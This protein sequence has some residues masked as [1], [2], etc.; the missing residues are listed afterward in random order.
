M[1]VPL[2]VYRTTYRDNLP[3]QGLKIWQNGEIHTVES[4]I[5]PYFLSSKRLRLKPNNF[6]EELITVKPLNDFTPQEFYKYSF[7]FVENVNDV[8]GYVRTDNPN[9]TPELLQSMRE[10]HMVFTERVAIDKP[11][12][13]R[14]YPDNL[15]S[16]YCFDI[17]TLNQ[18]FVDQNQIIAIS[19]SNTKEPAWCHIGRE[20]NILE[21]FRNDFR[22]LDPD[23]VVGFNHKEF[24][25][26]YVL[27]RMK[28]HNIETDF[29]NRNGDD[30]DVGR[31]HTLHGRCMYDVYENVNDDQTIRTKNKRLKTVARDHF[32]FPAIEEDLS[33]GTDYLLKDPTRLMQYCNSDV[34]TTLKI[35]DGY[36]A[37]SVAIANTIGYP[38]DNLNN[39][40][41]AKDGLD[42][43]GRA[44][45]GLW[46]L[47]GRLVIGKGMVNENYIENRSNRDKHPWAK[48]FQGA[49]SGIKRTGRF[50]NVIHVDV[51][52]M[53]PSIQRSFNISPDTT[54]FVDFEPFD[55]TQHILREK[56]DEYILFCIPDE[57][58]KQNCII[59]V[60]LTRT[61][62]MPEFLTL[63]KDE[64]G[65]WE[66][67]HKHAVKTE[68]EVDITKYWSL[69]YA[70]KVLMNGTGYGINTP[71]MVRYGDLSVGVLITGI[72]RWIITNAIEW[73]E[74][75]GYPCIEYDTDGTY[76]VYGKPE[77][78]YKLVD[79][80]NTYLQEL[81]DQLQMSS[82]IKMEGTMWKLMYSYKIKNYFLFGKGSWDDNKNFYFNE[83]INIKGSAFKSSAQARYIDKFIEGMAQIIIRNGSEKE[84]IDYI[85]GCMNI[86]QYDISELTRST[87]PTMMPKEYKGSNRGKTLMLLAEQ[88][89]SI[90]P[91]PYSFYDYMHTKGGIA[92]T[93]RTERKNI[94]YE[95]YRRLLW[96]KCKQF[97]LKDEAKKF[98]ADPGFRELK[99]EIY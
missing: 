87:R 85:K 71:L 78:P 73:M 24:D 95:E 45:S 80:L 10:N 81:I 17:E 83:K 46:T 74:N 26:P 35:F 30:L 75:Q 3:S 97:N 36:F 38:L 94:D 55:P 62:I 93:A 39:P 28:H 66:K 88:Q 48:A 11:N 92:L 61:G 12:F 40:M 5:K 20:D 67:L 23:V 25:F 82:E 56:T 54:K 90:P 14:Q 47:I 7:T 2:Q 53:Y 89:L 44:K 43:F 15:N 32:D 29:F 70:M 60:D 84:K 41:A 91:T 50:E 57:N 68:N 96:L 76:H 63:L 18:N 69:Q 16:I 51:S 72:G 21:N 19:Q 37:Q 31:V 86:K 77:Y 52:G 49:F 13:Y 98:V 33:N 99:Q 9:F 59:K 42:A 22:R 4:P 58:I 6:D 64:R 1:N 8:N 27:R 79:D 65:K 34:D